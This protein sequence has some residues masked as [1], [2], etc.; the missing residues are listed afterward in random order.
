MVLLHQDE[1]IEKKRSTITQT[2]FLTTCFPGTVCMWWIWICPLNIF[3]LELERHRK[4]SLPMM[5]RKKKRVSFFFFFVVVFNCICVSFS[6]LKLVLPKLKVGFTSVALKPEENAQCS[7]SLGVPWMSSHRCKYLF[8]SCCICLW[9]KLREVVLF[10]NGAA[11]WRVGV[12]SQEKEPPPE[13]ETIRGRQ[14]ITVILSVTPR[15]IRLD[16]YSHTGFASFQFNKI[17]EH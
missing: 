6:G 2:H 17:N 7:T 13:R 15:R 11:R 4:I 10:E 12:W 1:F 5:N 9:V 3:K 8:M 14:I 16:V